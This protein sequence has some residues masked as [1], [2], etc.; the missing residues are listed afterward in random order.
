MAQEKA[1]DQVMNKPTKPTPRQVAIAARFKGGET[2]GEIARTLSK[3]R[4]WLEACQR[5][6]RAIRAVMLWEARKP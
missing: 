5:V 4:S 1:L 2:V 6:E 3:R